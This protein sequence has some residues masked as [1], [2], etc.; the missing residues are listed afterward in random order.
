MTK[1]VN[2]VVVRDGETAP[3]SSASD[4]AGDASAMMSGSVPICGSSIPKYQIAL[5]IGFSALFGGFRGAFLTASL[6]GCAYLYGQGNASGTGSGGRMAV[7]SGANIRG[8][9][10]LPPPPKSS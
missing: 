1:I 4:L 3:Q 8:M 5:M 9:S 2:G 7:R 6:F 10:D